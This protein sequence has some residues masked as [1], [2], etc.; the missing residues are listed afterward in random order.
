MGGVLI[1]DFHIAPR[2]LFFL[3]HSEPTFSAVDPRIQEALSDHG[4]GLIDEA[5]F[6]KRYT[7]ITGNT[8]PPSK[9]SLLGKFF[10][11]VLDQP[12]VDVLKELKRQGMRVVAGTNVIDAHFKH[13]QETGQYDIFDKLYASHHMGIQKPDRGFYTHILEK[14]GVKPGEA[15]FTDDMQENV[16]AAKECGLAAFLYT[17]AETLR[18]QLK[19]LGAMQ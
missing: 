5:G 16:D 13:H 12:T 15:F 2:I 3:G 17:D 9:G 6:W 18:S 1:R 19:S 7:E 8:P 4:K 14:E 10:T 11:P